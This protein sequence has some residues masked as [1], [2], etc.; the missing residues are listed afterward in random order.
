M[1]QGAPIGR[2]EARAGIPLSLLFRGTRDLAGITQWVLRC[3]QSLAALQLP[4]LSRSNLGICGNE[5]NT[6]R[7]TPMHYRGSRGPQPTEA[8]LSRDAGEHAST[9]C[10]WFR[11][12]RIAISF[13][14]STATTTF[15]PLP[16][17]SGVGSS[18]WSSH[19]HMCR[20]KKKNLPGSRPP[21]APSSCPPFP[22]QSPPPH[23]QLG[24][25][26]CCLESVKIT[27]F[28]FCMH[29]THFPSKCAIWLGNY[30]Y[31]QE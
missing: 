12:Q 8:V 17:R 21:Q 3:S 29:N 7:D 11:V 2:Q 23:L 13:Q 18:W 14:I 27:S 16:T 26:F 9:G 1:H 15:S 28:S 4:L 20:E 30:I 19:T 5:Q 25:I 24:V 31:L 6:G 10:V 22:T